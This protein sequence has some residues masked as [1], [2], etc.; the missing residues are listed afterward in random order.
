MYDTTVETSIDGNKYSRSW[1]ARFYI[2]Y[3]LYALT[4]MGVKRRKMLITTLV[5]VIVRGLN[6]GD[7]TTIFFRYENNARE[8]LK[9]IGRGDGS[10]G[11][12]RRS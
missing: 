5:R 3:A 2:W 8:G 1:H 6:R 9:S 11:R 7:L 4:Q 12:E 10:E